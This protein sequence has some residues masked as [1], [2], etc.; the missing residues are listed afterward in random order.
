MFSILFIF[1]LI[2]TGLVRRE[3]SKFLDA[4]AQCGR[5]RF[6]VMNRLGLGNGAAL[7]SDLLKLNT[8]DQFIELILSLTYQIFILHAHID[9]T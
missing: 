9:K 2:I 4:Y 3:S 1:I 5:I 7:I 6:R 8:Y